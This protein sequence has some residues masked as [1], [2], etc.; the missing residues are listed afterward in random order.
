MTRSPSR[1]SQ[2]ILDAC[3]KRMLRRESIGDIEYHDERTIGEP[4]RMGFM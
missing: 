2:R 1:R 3:R 4:D